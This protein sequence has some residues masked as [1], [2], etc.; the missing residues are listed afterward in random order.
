MFILFLEDSLESTELECMKIAVFTNNKK[1]CEEINTI[2][3]SLN[4]LVI[5]YYDVTGHEIDV[6]EDGK[7]FEENALKKV[8]AMPHSDSVIFLADDSGIEVDV[9]GG[10]PGI[11]SARY[12][13]KNATGEQMCLK[14]LNDVGHAKNRS[15]RFICV[16]AIRF[17]D[18]SLSVISRDV[19]GTLTN[20][21]QGNHGF[22]YDPIFIPHG[23]DC[24][25]AELPIE[26]KHQISHRGQ[27][28]RESQKEISR[29]LLAQSSEKS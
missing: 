15:A 23:Y 10:K 6:V 14:L 22:G 11:Y 13:G 9:L 28:L 1:K 8:I 26:K 20:K 7:T 16:I 4:L 25:F 12:A 3:S 29:Y 2:F 18:G 5:P 19:S 24:T 21:L 27:A 17:P